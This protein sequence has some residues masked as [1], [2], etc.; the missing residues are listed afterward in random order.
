MPDLWHQCPGCF[1]AVLGPDRRPDGWLE[2][3]EC[4]EKLT[5]IDLRDGPDDLIADRGTLARPLVGDK[6]L[7][8]ELANAE[9]PS[10]V[11]AILERQNA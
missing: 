6:M 5:V 4:G 10:Q 1:G 2:C 9:R 11:E 3:E 8:C 7:V